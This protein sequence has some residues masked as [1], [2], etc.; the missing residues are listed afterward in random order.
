LILKDIQNDEPYVGSVSI[1]RSIFLE[2]KINQTHKMWITLFDDQ[3][4]DE[5][6]GAMGLNDDEDPRVLMEFTVTPVVVPP[7]VIP[8]TSPTR[9]SQPVKPTTSASP[10]KKSYLDPIGQTKEQKRTPVASGPQRLS[11]PTK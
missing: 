3:G 7:P 4:D 11:S 2:G 1:A 9:K 10:S 6:D 8:E 5:Y